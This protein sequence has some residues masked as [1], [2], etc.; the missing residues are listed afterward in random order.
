MALC[1]LL[2]LYLG[3]FLGWSACEW[4]ALESKRETRPD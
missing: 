1:V 3:L 2:A 4:L